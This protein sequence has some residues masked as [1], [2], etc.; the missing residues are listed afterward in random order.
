M[1]PE[2]EKKKL[3]TILSRSHQ[4]EKYDEVNLEITKNLYKEYGVII[5]KLYWKEPNVF[6][7]FYRYDLSEIKSRIKEVNEQEYHDA[8]QESFISFKAQLEQSITSSIEYI[9]N[10]ILQE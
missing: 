7:N 10:Y 5:R 4:I 1:I 2:K 6:G 8:K 3:I 9:T